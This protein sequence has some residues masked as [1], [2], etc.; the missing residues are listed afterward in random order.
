MAAPNLMNVSTITAKI[1]GSNLS[2]VTSSI[3]TNSSSSNKLYKVNSIVV[4]NITASNTVNT[5]ISIYKSANTD[6]YLAYTVN[7][8][9]NASLVVA[10]KDMNIYLEENDAIR[11]SA[12]ANSSIQ[13]LVSYDE[14][15]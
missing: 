14:V 6:Y 10:S 12:G 4:S 2:N 9:N 11:G 15:S 13:C 3:L 1:T 5:T 8:P 7:V